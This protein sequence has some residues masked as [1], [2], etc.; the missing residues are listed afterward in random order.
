MSSTHKNFLTLNQC[1]G[2]ETFHYGSGSE[3]SMSSGSGSYFQKVPDPVSDPTF[4]LKKHYFNGPKMAFQNIIF[5]EYLNLVGTGIMFLL[6][7]TSIFGYGPGSGTLELRIRIRQKVP[8][9]C[10]SGSTTLLKI[11]I[12]KI[13]S[14]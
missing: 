2:F 5:E 6:M 10:R 7:F 11:L 3:F 8:D 14:K 12:F 1:C 4:F 9:P 13:K